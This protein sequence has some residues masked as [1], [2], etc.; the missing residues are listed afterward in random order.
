METIVDYKTMGGGVAVI[1]L[2][3]AEAANA[4]SREMLR[5][6]DRLLDGIEFNPGI[7]G[8]ILTG[9]GEKAFCAGADLK[10]RAG[11]ND[12]E[13]KETVALIGKVVTKLERLP[14][15]TAA[16]INGACFGGGLELALACDIRMA[17]DSAKMG[18]TETSL[19]IIPGAGGTQRLPRLIGISRA[20]ELIYTARRINAQDALTYG[21]I[22]YAAPQEDLLDRAMELMLEISK[23]GP[24]AVQQAKKAIDLGGQG[25]LETGLS[26]E[27]I[28]YSVTIPTRD[29][30]EGL[31]A[32]KEK[33][34][35]QY[36][37]E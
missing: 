33:R 37:G 23:N 29:R 27:K 24:I 10:E 17:A 31:L 35:P 19:G 15:P 25:D 4:L 1:T 3:R 5:E 36:T 21:L 13:V 9:S 16:A 2:N 34:Q 26:I 18:L 8:V 7:R 11:M 32:F 22:S 20:K 12:R 14:Q 30:Q 6:L 28:C